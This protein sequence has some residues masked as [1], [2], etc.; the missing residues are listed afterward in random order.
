MTLKNMRGLGVQRL[1]AVWIGATCVCLYVSQASSQEWLGHA[2]RLDYAK[3]ACEDVHSAAC[4]PYLAE[5]VGIVDYLHWE[6]NRAGD[7]AKLNGLDVTRLALML[8]EKRYFYWSHAVIAATSNI[9]KL[10]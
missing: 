1:I 10:P 4:Q 2:A 9:C 8:D 3:I 6:T 7:C 5:A